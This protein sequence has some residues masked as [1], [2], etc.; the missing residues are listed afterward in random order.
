MSKRPKLKAKFCDFDDGAAF[1]VSYIDPR[2]SE[3]KGAL[4]ISKGGVEIQGSTSTFACGMFVWL[5][6]CESKNTA[7]TG[8]TSAYYINALKDWA[9]NWDGWDGDEPIEPRVNRFVGGVTYLQV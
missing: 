3:D 8:R 7:C 6:P 4:F 9:A 2:W 1:Y 5:G